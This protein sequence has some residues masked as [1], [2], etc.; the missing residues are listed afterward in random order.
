MQK[1][2]IEIELAKAQS[3][4]ARLANDVA[5][6]RTHDSKRIS[7]RTKARTLQAYAYACARCDYYESELARMR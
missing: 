4:R 1:R 2:I 6:M 5:R 7:A 3:E